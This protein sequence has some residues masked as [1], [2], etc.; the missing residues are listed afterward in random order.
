MV[1]LVATAFTTSL[2]AQDT[3]SQTQLSSLLTQY[4]GIKDA[5]VAGNAANASASAGQFVKATN[6]LENSGV[7]AATLSALTKDASTISETS[8]I[9]K[10]REAFALFSTNMVALAK[11]TKLTA[12]PVY[13]QY[14]PMKKADWLSSDKAIKNPYYGSAMLTCGKVVE[15]INQ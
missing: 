2:F 12:Q 4:Y 11:A 9:K 15:T 6:G 7:P 3:A 8:D 10:Q 1:A 14:C 5:L 13:Q